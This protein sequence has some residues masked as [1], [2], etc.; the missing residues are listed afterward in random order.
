MIT[1]ACFHRK[2]FFTFGILFLAIFLLVL[3]RGSFSKSTT[4]RF[5]T[6]TTD[7]SP[8]FTQTAIPDTL[9]AVEMITHTP[10]PSKNILLGRLSRAE[11]ESLMIAVPRIHANR[12]GMLMHREAFTAFL[13]MK[14]QAKKEGIDLI[15]VSAFRNF[16]HQKR[17]W[18]NKWNG[19][20]PLSGNIN[21]NSISDPLQRASEILKYSAMPGTSRHHWG[22]D[23]DINSLNNSYFAAGKGKKEYD[24]LLAHAHLFGF[25]QPYSARSKRNNQ[26]Y[27]E[28]K[29]H[30][31][32]LPVASIYLEAFKESVS[33][34][35]LAGF[36]GFDVSEKLGIINN[37]VLA[38]DPGCLNFSH[39]AP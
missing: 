17:I 10:F 6:I 29:W 3:V 36:D 34:A 30:W 24:W 11:T 15:I 16:D 19:Q 8:G 25:Y 26:G 14:E 27:E 13:Q 2:H 33:Y 18:E 28:E 1:P 23:I 7:S 22:T 21:A 9:K 32:Y 4:T 12:E 35:D 39:A 31:S 5:N 20:Q 38:I 37:Y